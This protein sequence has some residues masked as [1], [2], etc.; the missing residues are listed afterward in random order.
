MA[1]ILIVEDNPQIQDIIKR[2]LSRKGYETLTADDGE[3]ALEITRREL[4]DLIIMDMSLPKKDGWQATFELKGDPQTVGIP[5]IALTAHAMAVHRE[6]ALEAGCD[7][8]ETKPIDFKELVPKIKR[9]LGD[10]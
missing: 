1:T 3:L 6:K 8:Y 5:I 4:P 7:D 2:R 10:E 9:L